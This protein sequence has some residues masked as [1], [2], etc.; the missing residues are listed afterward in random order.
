MLILGLQGSPRK[1]GNTDTFLAAFLE[2]AGQAGAAVKT[3]QVARAGIV[4]CKG[5]G[6]CETHGTCVIA[7][8][9]YIMAALAATLSAVLLML[10]ARTVG[11]LVSSS[12][13]AVRLERTVA[14]LRTLVQHGHKGEVFVGP[15]QVIK[16]DIDTSNGVIH[17]IDRV[18]LPE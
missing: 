8:D 12:R 9:P 14:E 10:A 2:K 15:A 16:A 17:V 18:L 13:L 11:E 7:D 6:Y 1:G 5:C 3:I 4:P